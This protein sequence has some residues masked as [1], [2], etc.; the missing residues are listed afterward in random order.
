MADALRAQHFHGLAHI[1]GSAPL[2]GMHGDAQTALARFAEHAR[3][4]QR[5][6]FGFVA[7]QIQSDDAAAV[8]GPHALGRQARHF[9]GDLDR[10]V[11]V[12]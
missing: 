5:G 8:V 2:A 12:D 1:R 10:L 3:E 9:F 6:E 7:R 11:P 4:G